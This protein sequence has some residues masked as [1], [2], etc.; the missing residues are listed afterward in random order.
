VRRAAGILAARHNP[1][2]TLLLQPIRHGHALRGAG[3]FDEDGY[4][5][6]RVISVELNGCQVQIHLRHIE[7]AGLKVI[8]DAQ[9]HGLPILGAAVAAGKAQRQK[10]GG[11][12][13]HV[14]IIPVIIPVLRAR[15]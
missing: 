12:N 2:A 11:N 6:I 1:F 8:H 10:K 7:M 15:V 5:R 4:R 3:S 13:S 14:S 9:A